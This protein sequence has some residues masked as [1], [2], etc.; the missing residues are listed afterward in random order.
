MLTSD[1]GPGT[2]GPNHWPRTT[3][4]ARATWEGESGDA[5][6]G[7]AKAQSTPRAENSSHQQA[8]VAAKRGRR[9]RSAEAG[10]CTFWE[11]ANCAWAK[12]KLV[13]EAS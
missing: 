11:V 7:V 1:V 9:R 8:N 5:P 13:D 10:G 2:A 6:I 12:S 3:E 4:A